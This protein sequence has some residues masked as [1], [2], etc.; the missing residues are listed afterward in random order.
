MGND[1]GT[2]AEPENLLPPR[3]PIAIIRLPDL[4]HAVPL[5]LALVEGGIRA[6][7]FT[8]T[9]RAAHAAVEEVRAIL[10]AGVL[11]GAGTVLDVDSARAS[12]VSG[13]QFLVTPAFLPE[14][15][16]CGRESGVPVICGALTP[17]EILSV[18]QAGA[19]LVKVFP[20][21]RLGPSYIMDILGPL[22]NIP[23][24]PTGGVDLENCAAFLDAG[25]YT[26]AVGSSLLDRQLVKDRDWQGLTAL[27]G[28]FV[29]ACQGTSSHMR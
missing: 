1:L 7:E 14:V 10:P 27:A 20:A 12:V 17:T 2:A 24:V 15:I 21:G 9:N 28:R 3:Q 6:L 23:L 8:L 26:V 25:A 11:V 16:A 22:P 18:W 29:R 19:A 13:A 5:S 4:T